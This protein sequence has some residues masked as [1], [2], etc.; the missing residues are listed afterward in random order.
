MVA[1]KATKAE[2]AFRPS[3]FPV[4]PRLNRM[5]SGR[6]EYSVLRIPIIRN[7]V[8]LDHLPTITCRGCGPLG[9]A[10]TTRPYTPIKMQI[11]HN[12][13]NFTKRIR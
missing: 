1:R 6:D 3:N 5:S 13:I 11:I 12:V 10:P 8:P 9:D 7:R 4:I 2:I